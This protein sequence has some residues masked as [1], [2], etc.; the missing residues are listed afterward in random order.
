MLG[1]L[2]F[3]TMIRTNDFQKVCTKSIV[4]YTFCGYF[5]A[6][7]GAGEQV[8]SIGAMSD[9]VAVGLGFDKVAVF[10][11]Q[12][13]LCHMSGCNE[14]SVAT[15]GARS[16]FESHKSSLLLPENFAALE[17]SDFRDV[18]ERNWLRVDV[19]NFVHELTETVVLIG[20]PKS[21]RVDKSVRTMR[22]AITDRLRFV[23]AGEL[24]AINF[25]SQPDVLVL[26]TEKPLEEGLAEKIALFCNVSPECVIENLDLD[27]LYEVPLA[28]EE[29]GLAK[30]V[31]NRLGLEDRKP[32]LDDWTKMVDVVKD[33]MNG[34]KE[35]V[36]ISLVG[37]YVSLHDAYISIVES[38]KHGGIQNYSNVNIKWINSE[39]V[40]AKTVD[41]LL[42]DSDGILVPGG[43][44]DRGIEGKI[45]AAQYA[46][47]HKIP[48]L[49][50]C[51]GMQIA[52]IEYAR[53]VLGYKDAN[54]S[55][56][57]PDTTHPVI[58][59]MPEQRDVEDLGGTMRLGLYPCKVTPNT[60]AQKVYN[61][62]LIYERHRHRY[63]FNNFYRNEITDKGMVISGQS[64][65]DKLVEMV[66]IPN[67][68]W[69]IGV[70]FHPEFKSRPNRPHPLFASFIK[71]ALDKKNKA[72]E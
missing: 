65:D 47:E 5:L 42:K 8:F 67:H 19:T 55:E 37:K 51:L 24:F 13:S 9:F 18:R 61:S 72:A 23:A 46:R 44:G 11:H 70:Q 59:L 43:F 49:G 27:T 16:N 57:N 31:C 20:I 53:N 54:S 28:L 17:R 33:L 2:A 6:A 38:L 60:L 4:I 14:R 3:L 21:V 64:P 35:E 1:H 7:F 26:R 45:I 40:T 58:D 52:V 41:K 25:N 62:D 66:E 36:T 22:A 63:E 48:Y 39:E 15:F 34:G 50:I 32:Q 68:P 12:P 29:E 10:I 56:L 71:A 30:V 69:Y